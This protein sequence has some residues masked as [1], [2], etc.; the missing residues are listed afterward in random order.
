MTRNVLN[1]S[2]L[3][4]P[5]ADLGARAISIFAPGT[6]RVSRLLVVDMELAAALLV[7]RLAGYVMAADPDV[8]AEA[9]FG[10]GLLRAC[11]QK[12]D[13]K[14]SRHFCHASMHLDSF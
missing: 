13:R 14:A 11:R 2:L 6:A 4:L 3:A 5:M 12:G 9:D 10:A 7:E 8:F 1:R